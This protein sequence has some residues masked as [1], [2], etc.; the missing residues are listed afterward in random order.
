M[1]KSWI[2]TI[3]E[4]IVQ[5]QYQVLTFLCTF[6]I[7]MFFGWRAIKMYRPLEQWPEV[8]S[9]VPD[10]IKEW[11]GEPVTVEVG[12][13]I[14]NWHTFE[15][16]TNDFVVDG[17]IWFQ[18]DPALISLDTVGKFS[19]ERGELIEKSDPS[20]KLIEKKLFAEYKIRLRFKI[21][22]AHV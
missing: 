11:G 8:E 10:K 17:V 4:G 21:G 1:K 3:L 6:A 13:Y 18:F 16:E 9:I 5:P 15:V 19:F 20:T 2:A 12:L 7:V 22:R 14:N